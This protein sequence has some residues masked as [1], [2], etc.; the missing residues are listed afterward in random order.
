MHLNQFQNYTQIS[1]ETALVYGSM[2]VCET[3]YDA[4][5]G[6]RINLYSLMTE[7]NEKYQFGHNIF[8]RG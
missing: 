6:I 7:E 3:K 8:L 2:P 1:E 5:T 4:R